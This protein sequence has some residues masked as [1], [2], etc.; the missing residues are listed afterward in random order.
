[1]VTNTE[2][3]SE[4]KK[5]P[6]MSYFFGGLGFLWIIISTFQWMIYYPDISQFIFGVSIGFGLIFVGYDHWW[7]RRMDKKIK[8]EHYKIRESIKELNETCD[9]ILDYSRT[10][11]EKLNNNF[12]GEK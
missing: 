12:G 10:E 11:I 7:K 3:K 5:L 9:R 8:S 6:L 1:M 2:I 4:G